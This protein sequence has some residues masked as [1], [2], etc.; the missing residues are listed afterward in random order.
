MKNYK[1]AELD[2]VEFQVNIDI[3]TD[4]DGPYDPFEDFLNTNGSDEVFI[5]EEEGYIG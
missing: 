5:G 2:I 1:K 3:I 4:S